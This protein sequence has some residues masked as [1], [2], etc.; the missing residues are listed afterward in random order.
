MFFPGEAGP[1]L[2]VSQRNRVN[3]AR[4]TAASPL[5]RKR[6]SRHVFCAI[7]VD[8]IL[9]PKPEKAG[10]RG[11]HSECESWPAGP[12][13][14]GTALS[15]LIAHVVPRSWCP[16]VLWS[17]SADARSLAVKWT[18]G[19]MAV[20]RAGGGER[21]RERGTTCMRVRAHTHGVW[22]TEQQRG[23]S[24]QP[25]T[26]GRRSLWLPLQTVLLSRVGARG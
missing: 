8:E 18:M 9:P 16:R 17:P 4:G 5:I 21:E 11:A 19:L 24:T 20:A 22:D 6:R 7:S 12:S 15:S 23:D 13:H 2:G 3:P 26:P 10:G 25:G 1:A 14:P